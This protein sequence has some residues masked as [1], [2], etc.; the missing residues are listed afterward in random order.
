MDDRE[1]QISIHL[2]YEGKLDNVGVVNNVSMYML[3]RISYCVI[4][5]PFFPSKCCRVML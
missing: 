4:L 2:L 1:S 3:L 5:P